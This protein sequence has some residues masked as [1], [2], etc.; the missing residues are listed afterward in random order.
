M[1]APG[2]ID[3]DK[4][5]A[6]RLRAWKASAPGFAR[7][8]A[9]HLRQARFGWDHPSRTT[10]VFGCQRSGTKM[11][12][13]V[14]DRSPETRIYH[15]NHAAAFDDFQ[16]RSD[17]TV[18]TLT[19]LSPAPAQVFKPICDSHRADEILEQFPKAR[20]MWV[21]RH[22]ND[23]ANSA[24]QKWGDHQRDVIDAVAQGNLH[25]W[26]WRTAR[27]PTEVLQTIRRVHRPDLSAHEGALLFWYM[28]N[29]FFFSLGLDQ[30]PEMLLVNYR[31]L[32]ET[33]EAAFGAA[34]DH[35]EAHFE[36]SF[37][38][39]VNAKSVGRMPPPAASSEIGTLCADLQ[40]RLDAWTNATA[41]S[42]TEPTP[43]PTT[44]L[45]S[46]ILVL[47]DTLGTGGAERYAVTISNWMAKQGINVTLAASPGEM[48]DGIS[49]DVNWQPT[50][51]N[52]IRGAL[53]KAAS[54]VRELIQQHQPAA[55]IANSLAL[56]IVAR[57]AQLRRRVPIINVAHGWPKDRYWKVGPFMRI[58]DVVVAVSPDVRQKL[59][60]AGM[61]ADRVEV[62][63]NGVDCTDLAVREGEIRAAARRDMGAQPGGLVVV[64]VGR[65]EA[66]KAHQN[67]IAMA[68][69]LAETHPSLRFAVVG[70][71]TRDAELAALAESEGVAD[72]VRFLGLRRDVANLLG[73][74]DIYLNCSDWEGMPLTTI[75]AMASGLPT[76]ATHT[77]GADQLLDETCGIVVPVGDVD[78]MAAA[79]ASLADDA[80]R[81]A[82]LGEVAQR[83][84]LA[85]FSHERMTQQLVDIVAKT[86]AK[87]RH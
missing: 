80:E 22:H 13:R 41:K 73:S 36:P 33:P 71:G 58:A 59:V 42:H 85:D 69:K 14:L 79:V 4:I 19:Q 86:V 9:K 50:A 26:G 5:D 31:A 51:L 28:R 2:G 67:I 23:V 57:A 15:E 11:V 62:V 20:A 65:L 25:H 75:E 27:I 30:H 63:Y 29:A 21:Y 49:P 84:A 74:A 34:F 64:A 55:I 83:R 61:D 18:R 7:R 6:E 68:A 44:G 39:T 52:H 38:D 32:V 40:D 54:L 1:T 60:A 24:V 77:E 35:A 37:V 70:C 53:P 56:T 10:F 8:Q 72:R 81:R 16:L 47:I 3:A 78:K 12:M 48:S 87:T 17:R 45:P 82:S 76:V 66:Q 43:M 46:P